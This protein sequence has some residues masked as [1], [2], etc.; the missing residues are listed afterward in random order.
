VHSEKVFIF[1]KF[2]KCIGSLDILKK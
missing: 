1:L 2:I